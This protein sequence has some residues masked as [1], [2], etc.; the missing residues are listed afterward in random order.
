MIKRVRTG[1]PSGLISMVQNFSPG[2]QPEQDVEI[3]KAGADCGYAMASVNMSEKTVSFIVTCDL[4]L[5]E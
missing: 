4:C 1:R 2:H 5:V 3:G